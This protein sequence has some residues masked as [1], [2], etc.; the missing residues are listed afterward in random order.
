MERRNSCPKSICAPTVATRIANA[1]NKRETLLLAEARKGLFSETD[2]TIRTFY[3]EKAK[4]NNFLQ[5]VRRRSS[6]MLIAAEHDEHGEARTNRKTSFTRTGNTMIDEKARRQSLQGYQTEEIQTR[7]QEF[8][9]G[10]FPGRQSTNG[11][12][13]HFNKENIKN[14]LV[15]TK[16]FGCAWPRKV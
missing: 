3:R 6:G 7:I 13:G 9:A 8:L 2:G 16:K 14:E 11:Q 5:K 12:D 15:L 10:D 1:R 4:A